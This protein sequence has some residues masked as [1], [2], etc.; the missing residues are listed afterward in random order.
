MCV[1][2][3]FNDAL[4][5]VFVAFLFIGVFVFLLLLLVFCFFLGG[6]IVVVCWGQNKLDFFPFGLEKTHFFFGGGA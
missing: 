5:N 4:I 3:F 1:C 2:V 6:G